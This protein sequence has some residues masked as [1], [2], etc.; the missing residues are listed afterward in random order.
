MLA[1]GVSEMAGCV[2]SVSL[3]VHISVYLALFSITDMLLGH[4]PKIDTVRR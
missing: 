4:K 1:A 2:L 3:Y